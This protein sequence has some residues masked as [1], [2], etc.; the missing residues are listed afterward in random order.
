M[1]SDSWIM[2]IWK[3]FYPLLIHLSVSVLGSL[4]FSTVILAL[5]NGNQEETMNL[6]MKY[7]FIVTFVLDGVIL[8]ILLYFFKKDSRRLISV[9][10]KITP[11]HWLVIIICGVSACLAVNYLISLSGLIQIFYEQYEEISNLLYYG[12][13]WQEVILMAIAAPALEEVL[14]R[15]LIYKRLRTYCTYPVALVISALLFGVYHGNVVQGVYAF[16]LGM[17]MAF[18]YERFRTI[19]APILFHASANLISVIITEV[20]SISNFFDSNAF[21]VMIVSI[22]IALGTIYLIQYN[23]RP[24]EELP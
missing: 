19:W 12:N 22:L 15:G 14:F 24:K 21:I 20:P 23:L 11:I 4:I 9:K 6:A 5:G 2:R 18:L 16:L 10:M 8:F 3:L 17:V 1:R 13:I 7:N